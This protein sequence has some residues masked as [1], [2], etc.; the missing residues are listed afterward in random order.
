ML[1]AWLPSLICDYYSANYFTTH[2]TY[3]QG[4]VIVTDYLEA[5][6]GIIIIIIAIIIIN[7]N[8]TIY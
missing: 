5:S 2:K 1:V 8:N 3:P 4:A 7:T 6:N